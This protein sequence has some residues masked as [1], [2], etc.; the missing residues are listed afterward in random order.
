MRRIG[1]RSEQG[2]KL[3][4]IRA[5]PVGGSAILTFFDAVLLCLA[6]VV[7]L[8]RHAVD[9]LIVV[10]LSRVAFLGIRAFWLKQSVSWFKMCLAKVFRGA[11]KRNGASKAIQMH[12]WPL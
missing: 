1:W 2:G 5:W 3:C 10:V 8:A 4:R 12:Q 7:D 11:N 6:I 9:A